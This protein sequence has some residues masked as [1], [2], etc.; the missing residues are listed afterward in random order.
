MVVAGGEQVAVEVG[1][2]GEAVALLLVAAQAEVGMALAARV[3]FARMFRVVENCKE[4]NGS[5][6]QRALF[7]V[8]QNAG[9]RTLLY[10]MEHVWKFLE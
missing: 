10:S 9:V 1:V 2:P 3:R 5:G 6:L 7:L 8:Q 4:N